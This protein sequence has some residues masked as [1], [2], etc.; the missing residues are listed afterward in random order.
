MPFGAA[1][2][3]NVAII[4]QT[5]VATG[6]KTP[7][8]LWGGS[9]TGPST[10]ANRFIPPFEGSGGSNKNSAAGPARTP[11]PVGGVFSN[12]EVNYPVAL[13]GAQTYTTTL[14]KNAVDSTLSA[15]VTNAATRG[16]DTSHTVSVVEGDDICMKIAPSGTPNAQTVV[17][18]GMLFTSTT[19]GESPLFGGST[20][21]AISATTYLP[22]GSGLNAATE[23]VAQSICATAGVIDKLYVNLGTAPGGGG[24]WTYTLFK[25]GSS[26]GLTCAI[27]GSNTA[28]ND[29]NAGHAVTI[30]AGDRISIE[31][32][33][34]S[35]PTAG[36][37]TFGVRW[38]PTIAGEGLM[39]A[40]WGSSPTVNVDR[41]NNA[42][43]N[44]ASQATESNTYN[45]VP[46]ACTI[47]KQYL[48]VGTGPGGV[49]RTRSVWLRQGTVGGSQA[50]TTLTSVV[51]DT[52]TDANDTTHTVSGAVG[53]LLDIRTNS[54]IS[55][56]I[57]V[58]MTVGM[59][60]TSP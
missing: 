9:L 17:Q 39:F 2:D 26:T 58:T 20:A 54:T 29:T 47:K 36:I 56:T 50:D 11:C 5:I 52:A 51:T 41:F 44:A 15:V 53:D 14:V 7:L 55:A 8:L 37:V 21:T 3:T 31:A 32:A 12:L 6:M 30:A 33:A 38:V 10:S 24:S 45:I 46:F 25:N 42:R 35:S 43:G 4:T 18:A 19:A 57:P 22:F 27:S 34:T 16:S 1:T 28:A 60:I 13:T 48:H 59:V 40:V 23:A 49:V